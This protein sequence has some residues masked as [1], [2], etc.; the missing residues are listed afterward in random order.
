MGYRCIHVFVHFLLS[1]VLQRWFKWTNLLGGRRQID[2]KRQF[3]FFEFEFC[4]TVKFFNHL[5]K[6]PHKKISVS[7]DVHYIWAASNDYFHS[8]LICRLV[9]LP[10][11]CHKMVLKNVDQCFPK[12]KTMS[13]NYNNN[14][15]FRRKERKYSLLGSW[16]QRFF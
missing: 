3:G 7:L 12:P 1:S 4:V 10:I 16:N 14:I 9:V 11:K 2:L 6:G 13:S 8:W 15:Q 5:K